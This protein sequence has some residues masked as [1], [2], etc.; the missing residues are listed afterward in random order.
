MSEKEVT[1]RL[2]VSHCMQKNLP[3]AHLGKFIPIDLEEEAKSIGIEFGIIPHWENMSYEESEDIW[4][5]A[6]GVK[7][8]DNLKSKNRWSITAY[9]KQALSKQDAK[10]LKHYMNGKHPNAANYLK[11]GLGYFVKDGKQLHPS[12]TVTYYSK[13]NSIPKNKSAYKSELELII[14]NLKYWQL[15]KDNYTKKEN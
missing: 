11:L 4:A 12:T 13:H 5:D 8:N 3:I 2:C 1:L 7:P 15:L 14:A 10:K 9:N 6:Y